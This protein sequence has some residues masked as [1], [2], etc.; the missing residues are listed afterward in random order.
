M[1][2]L[3]NTLGFYISL[4][5]VIIAFIGLTWSFPPLAK[6]YYRM[7]TNRELLEWNLP[8]SDTTLRTGQSNVAQKLWKR[9]CAMIPQKGKG[10]LRFDFPQDK[11]GAYLVVFNP[12]N[13]RYGRQVYWFYDQY[14]GNLL[15]GGGSYAIPPSDMKMGDKIFRASYDIHSGSIL[16]YTGRVVIFLVS[17]VA[18]TLPFTGFLLWRKKR[19]RRP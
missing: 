4:L 7:L 19:K 6:G 10:S 17:L 11:S 1:Y 9:H 16:G 15:N 12:D 14:S 3:H 8:V 5:A 13:H 18:A 2:D